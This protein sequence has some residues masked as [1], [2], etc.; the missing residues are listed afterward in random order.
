MARQRRYY[1]LMSSLPALP[2]FEQANRL[3]INEVRLAERLSML[4]PKHRLVVERTASF[5]AWQRQPVERTDEEIVASFRRI[6]DWTLS[7]PA[8][9]QMIEYRMDLRTVMAGLRRRHRGAP[10]PAAGESWGVGQWVSHIERHWEE[11][12][13]QLAF[14]FPWIA[15]ARQHLVAGEALA[16]E[17]LLMGLAW[18]QLDRLAPDMF[19]FEAILAYLF[20]WDILRRWLACNREVALTR[21]E[22]LVTEVIGEHEE[23][24]SQSR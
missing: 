9:K 23:L 14:I 3:P 17:R 6:A 4:D 1:T 10:A 22:T 18:G 13:F 21:F 11:P 12:D 15:Q 16:L 8:L 19:A 24:F 5:L 7:Y 20:K 2:R